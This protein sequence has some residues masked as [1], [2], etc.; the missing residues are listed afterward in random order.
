MKTSKTIGVGFWVNAGIPS[1]KRINT[2]YECGACGAYH[3]VDFWGDC[4]TDSERFY[5]IPDDATI[6]DERDYQKSK[7]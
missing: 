7:L 2:F 5:D 1:G 6:E 3:R 4:R